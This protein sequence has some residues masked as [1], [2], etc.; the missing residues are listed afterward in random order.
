NIKKMGYSQEKERQTIFKAREEVL[1]QLINEKLTDQEIERSKV[2][3][4]EKEI[5]AQIE[6]IKK[7]RYLTEEELRET[8]ERQGVTLENYRQRLKKDILRAKL[9]NLEVKSKIVITNEDIKAY[10]DK[11]KETY[12]GKRKYHLRNIIKRVPVNAADEFKKEI[13][14][15]MEQVLKKLE[16]GQ[17]FETLARTYSDSPIAAEGG[18]LGVFSPD[19]LS[20]EIREAII[21]KGIGEFTSIL[22]TEQG[23]QIFYIQNIIRSRDKPLEEVSA[24]IQEKITR[25]IMDTKFKAWIGSLR[26]RS[27]IKIIR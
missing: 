25:E 17:P 22:D 9:V 20:P 2:S 24:A 11:N 7:A 21:D 15:K 10:Y 4:A 27:H 13:R 5:D 3:V 6:I 12:T 16:A 1:Q 23:F 19:Q 14:L 26:E 8:L 18:D